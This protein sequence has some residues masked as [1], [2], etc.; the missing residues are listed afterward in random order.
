MK[1][2][3]IACA[4]PVLLLGTAMASAQDSRFAI[5]PSIG[6]T[7]IGVNLNFSPTTALGLRLGY[8]HFDYDTDFDDT[9][10]SYD[11]EFDK[12]SVSLLLDWHPGNGSFR[13]TAGA[14]A[15]SDNAVSIMATPAAGG[16]YTF[17]GRDYSADDIE[18]ISGNADFNKTTPYLGIGWGNLTRAPGFSMMLDI[19]VQ[20]QDSPDIR[21]GVQGCEL[22]AAACTRL[23]RDLQVEVDEL[24]D[25][26][27]DFEFWPVLNLGVYYRF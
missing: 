23:E 25:D 6:T 12:D 27:E 4:L 22:P 13:V 21:L 14:Y 7:G 26:A 20:F 16:T 1:R 19:G 24:K 8:N 17:N 3:M 5:G 15:H 2:Q 10:V 9:D 18:S 11:A